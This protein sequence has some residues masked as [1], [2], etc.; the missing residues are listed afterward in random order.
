MMAGLGK[1]GAEV[2]IEQQEDMLRSDTTMT[3]TMKA[4]LREQQKEA[5]KTIL[6]GGEVPGQKFNAWTREYFSYDPLP[7][8]RKVK[9]PI[10]ILQ[11]E[12]DR[13]VDQSHAALLAN[14][15]RSAG[16][17]RV[18]V[19]VFPTLN[20]L[21]LPSKTGSFSEYSHL[22]TNAVP[23]DVLDAIG[24]WLASLPPN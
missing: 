22:E 23:S 4:S 18:T 11:G 12:R 15:A 1:R 2:S 21:F 8:I 7:T 5:V 17:S 10:L 3:E 14:A 13:Q 20:H 19:K 24:A 16:N 9:Q 6:A